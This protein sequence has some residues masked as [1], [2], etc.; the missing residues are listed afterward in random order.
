MASAQVLTS[1]AIIVLSFIIGLLFFY[2][3]SPRSHVERKQQIEEVVSL[4]INF[5]IF[6]WIGK[7]LVR[8]SIFMEDPLAILAYPSDSSAF[9]L[10]SLFIGINI[11]YKMKRH[12]FDAESLMKTFVPVFLVSSFVYE[13]IEMIWQGNAY[14]WFYL[15][16][17]MVLILLFLV[18]A[19]QLSETWMSYLLV[20]LWTVGQLVLTFIAP[21]ATVFGFIMTQWYLLGLFVLFS[22]LFIYHRKR[23]S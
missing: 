1:I 10:A 16:L 4:L 13:F 5:V 23:V 12:Q 20:L 2:L 8:F 21:F 15:G 14:S 19:N 9:Y 18:G 3:T 17:L 22:G 7:I 11:I 6:I